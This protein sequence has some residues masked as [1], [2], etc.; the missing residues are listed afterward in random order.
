[1]CPVAK[2]AFCMFVCIG[3]FKPCAGEAMLTKKS[4]LGNYIWDGNGTMSLLGFRIFRV[5]IQLEGSPKSCY[6]IKEP[7]SPCIA[8]QD[9]F[10]HLPPPYMFQ[11]SRVLCP[12]VELFTGASAPC[13]DSFPAGEP[14]S[15]ILSLSLWLLPEFSSWSSRVGWETFFCVLV[16]PMPVMYS[17]HWYLST[18]ICLASRVVLNKYLLKLWV[19]FIFIL[20]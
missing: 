19:D 13:T 17:C 11:V 15:T 9:F 18:G 3:I 7:W 8:I 6:S 14:S 10:W 16:I 4:Q 12:L 1:M 20:Y 2:S 5:T